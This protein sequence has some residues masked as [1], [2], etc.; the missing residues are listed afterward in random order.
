[1]SKGIGWSIGAKFPTTTFYSKLAPVL[2]SIV[3]AL[4]VRDE[5]THVG[6]RGGRMVKLTSASLAKA[7]TDRA[8]RSWY[9]ASSAD[10]EPD[11]A[12][13][14]HRLEHDLSIGITL[15]DKAWRR[16][17][18]TLAADLEAVTWS[19][20]DRFGAKA[21]FSGGI[22]LAFDP[23]ISI[24]KALQQRRRPAHPAGVMEILD[25]RNATLPDLPDWT[26]SYQKLLDGVPPRTVRVCERGDVTLR[27]WTD[28]LGDEKA[29]RSA[30][31]RYQQW[32]VKTVP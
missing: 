2:R 25:R 24:P 19:V 7:M 5:L 4:F 17:G 16:H 31:K 29:L 28:A 1:M 26:A 30:C 12:V 27:F 20:V 15:L 21:C 3:D 13:D 8:N 32:L 23:P 10:A 18:G 14:C 6:R 9:L 11:V 22:H